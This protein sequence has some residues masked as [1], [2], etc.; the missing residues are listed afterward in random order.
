MH[1]KLLSG[2]PTNVCAPTTDCKL[3]FH[4]MKSKCNCQLAHYQRVVKPH[5]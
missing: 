4:T 5:S 2:A 1:A 3:Y